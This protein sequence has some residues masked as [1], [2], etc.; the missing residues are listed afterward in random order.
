MNPLFVF[1]YKGKLVRCDV[2]KDWQIRFCAQDVYDILGIGQYREIPTEYGFVEI[3]E[4]TP[5]ECPFIPCRLVI[6]LCDDLEFAKFINYT[7]VPHIKQY[8]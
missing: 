8:F 4:E 7:I 6:E 3:E 5:Y 2:T 1:N